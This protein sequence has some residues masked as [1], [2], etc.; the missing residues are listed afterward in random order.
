[1][2]TNIKAGKLL[3]LN[4]EDERNLEVFKFRENQIS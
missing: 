1:M 4:V 3:S 2:S